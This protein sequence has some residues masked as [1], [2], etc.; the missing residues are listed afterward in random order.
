MDIKFLFKI[1]KN[2]FK[3][4]MIMMITLN[5]DMFVVTPKQTV[6]FKLI[7]SWI[8]FRIIGNILRD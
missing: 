3:F 2:D 6:S 7:F 5:T 4:D 1:H 8:S